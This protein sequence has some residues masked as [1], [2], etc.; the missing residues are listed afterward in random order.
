MNLQICRRKLFTLHK[1]EMFEEEDK[2]TIVQSLKNL[3]FH[4]T[5]KKSY[6]LILDIC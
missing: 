1:A 4:R 2:D 6:H 3:N 5:S